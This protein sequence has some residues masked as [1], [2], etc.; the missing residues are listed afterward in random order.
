MSQKMPLPLSPI[1]SM[2]LLK[3]LSAFLDF[4]PN[5]LKDLW[6][7]D[8]GKKRFLEK[9]CQ[10]QISPSPPKTRKWAN[11][12]RS[13]LL[14]WW[15]VRT[16]ALPSVLH[17]QAGR[18]SDGRDWRG[19]KTDELQCGAPLVPAVWCTTGARCSSGP[20]CTSPAF[21]TNSSL[22]FLFRLR[23][24]PNLD[25]NTSWWMM[26]QKRWLNAKFYKK[27]NSNKAGTCPS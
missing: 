11:L 21:S 13:P 10:S 18:R 12:Q 22:L 24:L 27:L 20:C 3:S 4:I 26:R 7:R 23:S 25:G 9:V 15:M 17:R 14:E 8:A 6:H 19:I 2:Y 5:P 16:N 1:H